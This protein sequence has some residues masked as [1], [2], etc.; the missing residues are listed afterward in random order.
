MKISRHKEIEYFLV[1]VLLNKNIIYTSTGFIYFSLSLSWCISI[2]FLNKINELIYSIL[3]GDVIS[4]KILPEVQSTF[5]GRAS[6][7]PKWAS[8]IPSPLTMHPMTTI[9]TPRTSIRPESMQ[10]QLVL[11]LS[12]LPRPCLSTYHIP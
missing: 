4:Y 2:I 5:P 11:L 10:Q 8:F 9:V 12:P 1:S 3:V 6:T 7:H